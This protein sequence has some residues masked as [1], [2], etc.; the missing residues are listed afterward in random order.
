M[1]PSFWHSAFEA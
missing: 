1:S